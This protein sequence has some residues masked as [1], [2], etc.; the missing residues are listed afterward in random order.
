MDSILK[1]KVGRVSKTPI[2]K[3]VSADRVSDSTDAVAVQN[4]V[5]ATGKR[6]AGHQNHLNGTRECETDAPIKVS[7]NKGRKTSPGCVTMTQHGGPNTDADV[8]G[9]SRAEGENAEL[10][11][12]Y[13]EDESVFD[14]QLVFDDG[15]LGY[16]TSSVSVDICMDRAMSEELPT[17]DKPEEDASFCH[18]DLHGVENDNVGVSMNSDNEAVLSANAAH[19]VAKTTEE[20]LPE[21]KFPGACSSTSSRSEP[22]KRSSDTNTNN[23]V[24]V[25]SD[26]HRCETAETAENLSPVQLDKL[27]ASETDSTAGTNLC[28]SQMSGKSSPHCSQRS[29][30]SELI[31]TLDNRDDTELI[32]DHSKGT[33]NLHESQPDDIEDTDDDYIAADKSLRRS[34]TSRQSSRGSSQSLSQSG[35][36][37]RCDNKDSHKHISDPAEETHLHPRQLDEAEAANMGCTA[38]DENLDQG[39]MSGKSSS[40]SSQKVSQSGLISRHDSTLDRPVSSSS[41]DVDWHLASLFQ[42]TPEMATPVNDNMT[43]KSHIPSATSS[44]RHTASSASVVSNDEEKSQ[45][46]LR[47][48]R[49]SSQSSSSSVCRLRSGN[50]RDSAA[51]DGEMMCDDELQLSSSDGSSDWHLASMYKESARDSD[52]MGR[53]STELNSHSSRSSKCSSNSSEW[54][55]R[56]LLFENSSRQLSGELHAQ[57]LSA[58]RCWLL[59][60]SVFLECTHYVT[61]FLCVHFVMH[62]EALMNNMC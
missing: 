27:E 14:D 24:N 20:K 7:G 61:C 15:F 6:K 9:G 10:E 25:L 44:A 3:S 60:F 37:T 43:P 53:R 45:G 48:R 42:N 40:L 47:S 39:R 18:D 12:V 50:Y 17:V 19:H 38:A 31:S 21:E 46:K 54:H 1:P 32:F 30:K 28:Q 22:V 2:E 41:S 49:S 11:S 57:L 52:C 8:A 13:E 55:I 36:I 35:I 16:E 34:R 4:T 56:S 23:D 33:Q 26:K 5:V 58:C 59:S 62:N 51:D 29:S